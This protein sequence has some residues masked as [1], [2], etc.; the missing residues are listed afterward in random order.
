MLSAQNPESCDV[1]SNLGF[2]CHAEAAAK[3]K[4]TP[5]MQFLRDKHSLKPEKKTVVVP[6]KKVTAASSSMPA[7]PASLH[8]SSSCLQNFYSNTGSSSIR[9]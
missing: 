2:A 1:L 6:L 5:L 9:M 4:V 3:P 8:L 7:L